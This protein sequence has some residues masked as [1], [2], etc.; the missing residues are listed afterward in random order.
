MI[1][2][3]R[4]FAGRPIIAA[5]SRTTIVRRSGSVACVISIEL[6]PGRSIGSPGSTSRNR[7]SGWMLRLILGVL[8]CIGTTIRG[9]IASS[10]AGISGKSIVGGPPAA[11]RTMSAP[12]ERRE[13]GFGKRMAEVA[14]EHKVQVLGAEMDDRH[15]VFG[16]SLG[17]LEDVDRLEANAANDLAFGRQLE[18][19]TTS[20]GRHD[21]A[22]VAVIAVVFMAD[23]DQVGRLGDRLVAARVGRTVR[24]EDDPQALRLDQKRRVAVPGDPHGSCPR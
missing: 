3:H 14:Q 15:F 17:A 8:K 5:C 24:V 19:R 21:L 2:T 7:S 9:P 6:D 16:Q 22:Q 11:A 1:G 10:S 18:R 4:I 23:D 20:N 12:R 13:L